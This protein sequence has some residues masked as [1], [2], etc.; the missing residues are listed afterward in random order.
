MPQLDMSYLRVL[1]AHV[2]I[3]T[4]PRW[5]SI[6]NEIVSSIYL[7]ASSTAVSWDALNFQDNYEALFCDPFLVHPDYMKVLHTGKDEFAFLIGA[8]LL[9]AANQVSTR[10]EHRAG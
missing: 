1:N 9:R 3:R 10:D 6:C 2:R 8:S 4:R 5:T 7:C